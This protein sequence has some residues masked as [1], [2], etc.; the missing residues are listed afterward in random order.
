VRPSYATGY[1]RSASESASPNWWDGLQGAWC[2][3]IGQVT[4]ALQDLS[5]Y[6]RNAVMN[7]F[8]GTDWQQ[9][10]YG[11]V[12]DFDGA[13]EYC[14]ITDG[15][16]LEFSEQNFTLTAFV[17][18]DVVNAFQN[19][20]SKYDSNNDFWRLI[21]WNDG[22]MAASIN[23]IEAFS[24]STLSADTWYAVAYTADQQGTGNGQMW[25]NG[26]A[27]GAAAS[28]AAQTL[29]LATTNT[30]IGTDTGTG[31]FLNGQL[32]AC[33]I[34]NRVLTPGEIKTLYRDPLAP[35]RRRI[36]IP[37]ATDAAAPPAGADFPFHLYYA[38]GGVL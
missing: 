20:F 9:S 37:L 6:G 24:T 2:P 4:T 30:Y 17:K 38:G 15:S 25:I 13:A 10:Q 16:D 14:T 1:A 29:N 23:N 19:I 3:A 27:D 11:T 33:M 7:A 5:G 18:F 26:V 36:Y 8:E 21:L 34:H 28:I 12:L 35:F 31:Q 32:A 22:R